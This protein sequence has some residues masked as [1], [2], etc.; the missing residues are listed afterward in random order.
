MWIPG[1]GTEER[2]HKKS[3]ATEAEKQ[4]NYPSLFVTNIHDE[5]VCHS[6]TG[7]DQK[8]QEMMLIVWCRWFVGNQSTQL[9]IFVLY[10]QCSLITIN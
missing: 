5:F 8:D 1:F 10:V 4:V 2:L 9:P 3:C 7:D 6:E